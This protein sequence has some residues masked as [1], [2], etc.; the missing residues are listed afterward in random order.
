[1]Q[2]FD[3][4]IRR[5]HEQVVVGYD[6]ETG[7]KAIIAIHDTTLGPALGGTR[8]W[9]YV[10][11]DDALKDVIRLSRGMTY[12]AAVSGLNLGGGKGVIIGNPKTD[13]NE[14]LFRAYG[15]LVN[16]LGGLYI[17]AEDV[18]TS[19]RDMEWVRTETPFVTGISEAL[20]GSG[21]P[22][23]VT[24]RGVYNGMKAC[25]EEAFGTTSLK[26][27]RVAVQGVG[28]VGYYLCELLHMEGAKLFIT[29]I[30]QE[31]LAIAA[32]KFGATI[33]KPE[34]IY[35]VDADIF[36][37][38][39]LGAILN[40]ETIPQFK[41]KIVAGAANNQLKIEAEN[42][43]QLID[44]GILYAPDYVINAGGLINVANEIEGYN[45]QRALSQAD[46]IYDILKNVIKVSKEENIPTY[47]AS[48]R[49]AER[50]IEQVGRLRRKF[51]NP[52]RGS[53][54]NGRFSI[55]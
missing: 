1:M 38:C 54:H 19:V 11:E 2:T 31:S 44:R 37:P 28:H 26:D 51:T 35:G 29:D 7:L 30:D 41:F 49:I 50:R 4:M 13:K 52:A 36:A 20:G 24:A 25:T 33:V 43:P 34:E 12:K 10:S 48:N 18:G 6:R 53:K 39:A 21:D 8:M 47:V 5:N 23:P 42:G 46:G 55:S 3:E 45:R 15:R 16:S 40:E 14:I 9:N 27:M 32:Q 22:S 17:T